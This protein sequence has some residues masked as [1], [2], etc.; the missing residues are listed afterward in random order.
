MMS[1]PYAAA[2]KLSKSFDAAPVLN[3]VSF[4]VQPGD[5]IGVL[6]KNGAGKTTLLE[7]MLGFSRPTSG[8]VRLFG[9]ESFNMPG[10]AKARVGFVPQ[11]DE[12]INQLRG[13]EQLRVIG[14]FY[15][16]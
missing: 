2:H 13:G 9:N 5:V 4:E 11:Q 10:E 8:S 12:L 6:G 15:R 14:S 1:E 7:L 16:N 3:D